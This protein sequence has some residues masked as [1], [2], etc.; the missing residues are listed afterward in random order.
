VKEQ[1][2]TSGLGFIEHF[3]NTPRERVSR[4]VREVLPCSKKLT[5][6]ISVSTRFI[7]HDNLTS[8]AASHVRALDIRAAG[9]RP[10][11]RRRGSRGSLCHSPRPLRPG[12]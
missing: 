12:R 7:G 4:L 10:G 6:S 3:N 11:R 2:L 9:T 8:A 5:N 1:R